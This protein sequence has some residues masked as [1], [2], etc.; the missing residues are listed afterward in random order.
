MPENTALNHEILGYP[1]FRQEQRAQDQR[2][3]HMG[4][5]YWI[6]RKILWEHLPKHGRTCKN[7]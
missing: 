5:A 4:R 3:S 6:P 7:K 1:I 2:S